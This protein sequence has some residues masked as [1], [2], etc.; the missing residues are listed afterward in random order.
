MI[1]FISRN[2]VALLFVLILLMLFLMMSFQIGAEGRNPVQRAFHLIISPI[3]QSVHGAIHYGSSL[4]NNYLYL[5][6]VRQDNQRLK[7]ALDEQRLRLQRLGYIERSVR[8]LERLL[9]FGKHLPP[10]FCG[11]RVVAADYGNPVRTRVTIDRGR[12][13]GLEEEY[14]VLTPEGIVGKVIIA[15]PSTSV[16]E[17]INSENSAISARIAGK[18]EVV[19]V[20]WGRESALLVME[21]VKNLDDIKRD[22]LVVSAG[23]DGIYP[24]GHV[25]GRVASVEDG[26][27][28]F[29]DVRVEPAVKLSS[30]EKVL[31]LKYRPEVERE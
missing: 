2:R 15:G 31:V 7:T 1:D 14:P 26:E 24:S 28:L 18:E 3:Q 23:F 6:N 20:V 5:V 12:R 22:D 11:A 29:K 13:H 16:V 27:G 4:W 8:R 30:L 17:M 21:Y 19:G 10:E 25:I 9:H